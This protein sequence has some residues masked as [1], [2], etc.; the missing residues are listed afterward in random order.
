MISKLV[1]SISLDGRTWSGVPCRRDPDRSR[2]ALSILA[3]RL[4][5]A[6]TRQL[7]LAATQQHDTIRLRR[8]GDGKAAEGWRPKTNLADAL[9]RRNPREFD[10][11][12]RFES[13]G[14]VWRAPGAPDPVEGAGAQGRLRGID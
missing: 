2:A 13:A 14:R 9:H 5:R 1:N 4:H 12:L 10:S 11:D 3:Y 7:Y 6:T 8:Q